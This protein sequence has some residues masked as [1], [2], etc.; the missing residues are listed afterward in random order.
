MNP[1]YERIHHFHV[2]KTA[3]TSLN[4]AF[5]AL[6]GLADAVMQHPNQAGRKLSGNGLTFVR[7]DARLIEE[8]DYFFASSHTPAYMLTLPERTFTVTILRDPAARVI[9]YYRYLCWA[10][11]NPDDHDRDPFVGEVV[12][13]SRFL[14]G[15]AGYTLGQLS[16]RGLGTESAIR[17]L[18]ARQFLRRLAHS[19]RGARDFREFLQ[20]VPPRRLMSQ[21]YMFSA[22]MDPGE[23]A[24]RLAACDSVC[25]TESFADD[26]A[27]LSRTLEVPLAE[28]KDRRLGG[29]VD[30]SPDE[31][32]L[33]RQRLEPEYRML[34]RLGELRASSSLRED[35]LRVSTR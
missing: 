22:G 32:A 25:F 27:N 31:E 17:Q 5:W 24:E 10:R 15:G 11:E 19:V 2:R 16:R 12:E 30:L 21:L 13:E 34:R 29:P 3:G 4:R 18:G 8:G 23:A 9:S 35:R 1:A 6:G 20:V 7:D 33:L 26:I 14:D 28:R